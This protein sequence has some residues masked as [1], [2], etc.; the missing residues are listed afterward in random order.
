MVLCLTQVRVTS[1]T[2]DVQVI[3]GERFVVPAY[4]KVS[5]LQQPVNQDSDE[6]L[7]YADNNSGNTETAC[8]F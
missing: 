7:E 4:S 6:E 8:N 2:E 5:L 3:I 1:C